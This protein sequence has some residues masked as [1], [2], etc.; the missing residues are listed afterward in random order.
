MKIRRFRRAVAL[1]YSIIVII[2]ICVGFQY[3]N[4]SDMEYREDFRYLNENWSVDGQPIEFPYGESEQAFTIKNTLPEVRNNE[5][6]IIRAYY[7]TFSA[8][9][10]GEEVE[11]SV[12]N[13]FL[14][15]STVAGKKE[16]W[17]PLYEKYSGKDISIDMKMRK[18]LYGASISEAF[19]T[20][21]ALYGT[22][23][24]KE[25]IILILF[26]A[27]F[28]VT[29]IIEIIIACAFAITT[30]GKNRRRI[31]GALLYAGIFSIGS[32]QWMLNDCRLTFILF[33]HIVG[34]SILTIL[35]YHILPLLF[36]RMQRYLY[37]RDTLV[38]HVVGD[39]ISVV[40]CIAVCLALFGVTE[41]GTLIYLGQIYAVVV[42][43]ATGYY[44]IVVVINRKNS[45]KNLIVSYVNLVFIVLALIS[46]VLY[47][48]N[49]LLRYV[50]IIVFDIYLYV[51][52]QVLLIYKTISMSIKEQQEH[53]ITKFY[54]FND[55]LTKLG[56]RRKF[57]L[58]IDEL[59]KN[60][61]PEDFT[62]IMVDSNRLKYYNDN[63][64][65]E[66]GDELIATT[67][68]ILQSTFEGF[69]KANICRIGGDE[70]AV[71][72]LAQKSEVEKAIILF[73]TRLS[74][75]KGQYINGM[76]ASV[77]YAQS[78]D[79]PG[80]TVDEL[81]TKADEAMYKDKS[82]FYRASG[83]DRRK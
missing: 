55:E 44:S 35:S 37:E 49:G 13:V 41:W 42:F 58:T 73:K 24:T 76:S 48:N 61:L 14:G 72:L 9:I 4:D 10:D 34:Y 46:L 25:N 67:A 51:L 81:Q 53:D 74:E 19:I 7:D 3:S 28:T 63:F 78:S 71:S 54:A 16:F 80:S 66:A 33:G 5:F 65:H 20:S 47:I 23:V 68:K 1:I 64:G 59:K 77:G 82:A 2:S 50:D 57:Y 38:D 45:E 83:F 22:R 21:R 31:F 60:G 36:F 6:L 75:Y 62:I 56:N 26:I 40:S 43:L 8:H 11:H 18:E 32:G 39:T 17:I 29:G 69:E 12:E 15:R 27:A 30:A 70:F 79:Y 52:A